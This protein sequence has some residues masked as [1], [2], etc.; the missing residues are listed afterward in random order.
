MIFFFALAVLIP[1]WAVLGELMQRVGQPAVMGQLIAEGA[2]PSLFGALAETSTRC[3]RR[4]RRRGDA[5]RRVAAR[6]PDAAVA[7]RHGD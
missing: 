7:H 4:A 6:H 5:R 2:R 1:C 3:S